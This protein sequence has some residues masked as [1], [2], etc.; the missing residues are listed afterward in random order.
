MMPL[1]LMG[2]LAFGAIAVAGA[3]NKWDH[4]WKTAGSMTFAD[5]NSNT[6]CAAGQWA[7]LRGNC[8]VT[9]NGVYV[10]SRLVGG[11]IVAELLH[12]QSLSE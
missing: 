10:G 5:F 8:V 6:L 3:A 7:P 2:L 9:T 11:Q 1:A 4:D 12:C